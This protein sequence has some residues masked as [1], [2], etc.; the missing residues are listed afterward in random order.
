MRL[1]FA[2][3]GVAAFFGVWTLTSALESWWRVVIALLVAGPFL[4]I[5][6]LLRDK[7]KPPPGFVPRKWEDEEDD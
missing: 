7:S 3:L 6:D 1:I 5:P 2:L 4:I